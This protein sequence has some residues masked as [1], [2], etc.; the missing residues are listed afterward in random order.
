MGELFWSAIRLCAEGLY[1]FHFQ[2]QH[3]SWS[4]MLIE[5]SLFI[6]IDYLFSKSFQ[7]HHEDLQRSSYRVTAPSIHIT[8]RHHFAEQ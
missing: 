3:E 1:I 2:G 8:F 7:Y 4:G 6:D 5:S